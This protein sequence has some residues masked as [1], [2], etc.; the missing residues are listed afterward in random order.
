MKVR[1]IL[2]RNFEYVYSVQVKRWWFPVWVQV[3]AG[4]EKEALEAAERLVQ[5]KN[6]ERVIFEGETK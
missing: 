4:L 1:V 6:L 2:K 3:M 5:G